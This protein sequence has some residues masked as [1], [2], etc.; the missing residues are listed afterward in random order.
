MK[1]NTMQFD[2]EELQI[3]Q[4]FD[5]GEFQSIRAFRASPKRLS[6]ETA[7]SLAASTC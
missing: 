3:L 2:E 7:R 5:R 6:A 4:D 1:K